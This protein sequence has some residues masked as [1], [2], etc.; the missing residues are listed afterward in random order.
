MPQVPPRRFGQSSRLLLRAA[1]PRESEPPAAGAE[2]RGEQRHAGDAADL[3]GD[4]AES[5][6][7]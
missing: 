7:E 3:G 1:E 2:D 6:G 5:H 4:V